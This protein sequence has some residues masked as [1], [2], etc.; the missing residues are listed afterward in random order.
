[1]YLQNSELQLNDTFVFFSLAISVFAHQVEQSEIPVCLKS[2]DA[3]ISYPTKVSH[4]CV[5]FQ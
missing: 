1:M 3:N 5:R 4:V 2:D